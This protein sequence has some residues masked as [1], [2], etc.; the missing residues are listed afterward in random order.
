[1]AVDVTLNDVTSGFSRSLINENFQLIETALQDAISRTGSTPNT[2]TVDLD[3]DGND[4]INVGSLY[5]TELVHKGVVLTDPSIL[6][7]VSEQV[8]TTVSNLL[9]S[10]EDSRGT[11][12]IW[13]AG[14]FR[15]IEVA[16]GGDVQNSA[17]TP[18]QLDVALRIPEVSLNILAFG[19]V[20]GGIVDNSAAFQAISDKN[21]TI[22]VPTGTWACSFSLGYGQRI[23]GAGAR[24][25]TLLIP[26]AGATEVI[27]VDATSTPK[28]HCQIENLSIEN[29]NAVA[30]CTGLHFKGTDATSINDS[31][32]LSNVYI[33]DFQYGIEVTGRLIASTFI[34]VEIETCTQAFRAIAD[35]A[36]YAYNLNT[37][38]ECR[39]ISSINEG[40]YQT[41]FN[42]YNSF[43][44]CN[45]EQNNTSQTAGIAG[46][47]IEDAEGLTLLGSYFELNGSGVAVDTGNVLNNS[48][49]LHLAG[50]R[51]FNVKV[52]NCWMVESG[53][54]ILQDVAVGVTGGKING[55]RFIPLT[56]GWDIYASGKVTA[57]D[58][59]V[60]TIGNDNNFGGKTEIAVNGAGLY[61][62]AFEQAST[63]AYITGALT[64][65][66]RGA[67]KFI[68][69]SGSNFTLSTITNRIPGMDFIV[70]NVGAGV[71]TIDAALMAN[72]VAS[73]IGKNESR[74]YL[75]GG[76]PT[77]GKLIETTIS[78][79]YNARSPLGVS[80]T[81]HTL[82]A[83]GY[84]DETLAISSSGTFTLTLPTGPQY[85]GRILNVYTRAANTVVSASGNV[86]P[87]TGGP[88]T[89]I[90]AA[91]VGKWATLQC[92]GTNWEIIANN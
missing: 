32:Y 25:G 45:I 73:E 61:S 86:I 72:G 18:V 59:N 47:Y 36:N 7:G 24:D 81:A 37:F 39:F 85:A 83:G 14:G 91:T 76:F 44:S 56:N 54:M 1:M 23:V 20:E 65:D 43:Y 6:V 9:S 69:N 4:L 15:Y 5:T 60:L 46:A 82:D 66:L 35:P 87:M 63:C 11:G 28:Q 3:L 8:Y 16:S 79:N 33:T 29:P 74:S 70:H 40:Y 30:N 64:I 84:V 12:A 38:I 90:L 19:A 67:S 22:F 26:P 10:T 89:A 34:N 48:I 71:V 55:C 50:N 58:A 68:A 53:V 78:P 17:G 62:A 52:D 75:V 88:S 27:L 92:N 51:C 42:S 31:H 77:G 80:G 57:P 49:G 21:E 2:M 41:G 13:E